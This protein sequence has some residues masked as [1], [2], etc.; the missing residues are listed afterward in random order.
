MTAF[1][2]ITFASGTSI[3]DAAKQACDLADRI[4]IGIDFTFNTVKC[5]CRPGGQWTKLVESWYEVIDTDC[6]NKSA[7]SK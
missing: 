2:T 4:Q 5:L 6:Q 7:R 1:L 3:E